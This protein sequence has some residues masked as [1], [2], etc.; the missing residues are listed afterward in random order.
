ME[1]QAQYVLVNVADGSV[2][3]YESHKTAIA[4]HALYGGIVI[5][6][7]TAPAEFTARAINDARK[8]MDIKKQQS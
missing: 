5:N 1:Y 8:Y 3:W 6:T 4:D 2:R 7:A